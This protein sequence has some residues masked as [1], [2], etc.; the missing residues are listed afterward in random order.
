MTQI[1]S[2]KI[3]TILFCCALAI[4]LVRCGGSDQPSGT[5]SSGAGGEKKTTKVFKLGHALDTTHPV[6]KAMVFMGEKLAEKSD[7]RLTLKI[8]PNEQL[9][10]ER[11]MIEQVQLGL[12]DLT[13]SSMAPLEGF[14]PQAGVFSVPYIFRDREHFW[15][16]LNS[17]VGHELL[18][19]GESH[20]LRG[21]CYYDAGS[22]SFYTR[23]KPI[24]T[25]EDLVGLKIRVMQ[26][27]TSMKMVQSLGGS[28]TP[29]DWGEL[30]TSLQQG[31][32]DGA[33]NNP[34]SFGT[35]RHYEVC[36]YYS[37]DEHTMIPDVLMISAKTWQSLSPED[38]KIVQEAADESSV[39]EI[40][41]WTKMTAESLEKVK[42][43]GV[44][45]IHPDKAPFQQ[46]VQEMQKEYEGTPIGDLIK[47][48]QAVE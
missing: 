13:K 43:A 9:G 10:S 17:D 29:I 14:I 31:V 39:Y 35:S 22:R 40:E 28:P 34:P 18:L 23:D 33:E 8:T 45:V 32:V 7:G 15:K 4:V 6:H 5:A 26:S 21:L 12:L 30:Y 11:E 2:K 3:I 44:E 16:A 1:I 27:Q 47:R 46:K 38:Q 36:K 24:R 20:G 41:L 25:P 42:E 48:I 37:L 19:A